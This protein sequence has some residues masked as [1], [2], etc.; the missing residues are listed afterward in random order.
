MYPLL[1]LILMLL[2]SFSAISRGFLMLN[3]HEKVCFLPLKGYKITTLQTKLTD[4]Y[5][6]Y[7][8]VGHFAGTNIPSP[9]VLFL[10]LPPQLTHKAICAWRCDTD[11]AALLWVQL[12]TSVYGLPAQ[13]AQWYRLTTLLASLKTNNTQSVRTLFKIFTQIIHP[14][15]VSTIYIYDPKSDD[16]NLPNDRIQ[17]PYS[18]DLSSIWGRPWT[19]THNHNGYI[20]RKQK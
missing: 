10:F 20:L 7:H 6:F 5:T 4:K 17:K 15:Y 13:W 9:L 18:S 1:L 3:T 8:K 12:E 14:F 11:S 16:N 19:Y 2:L